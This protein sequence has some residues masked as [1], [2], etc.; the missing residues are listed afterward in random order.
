MYQ[1]VHN[2]VMARPMTFDRAHALDRALKLFWRQGY[3]ATSLAQ[4]L[5]TMD[6]GRSSFYAAFGDKRSLFIEVLELFGD[7][8]RQMLEDVADINE[9]LLSIQRFFEN[10]TFH[11]PN[12]RADAG[13]M[14]VNTILELADV[15]NELCQ[16]ASRKLQQVEDSFAEL[17]RPS[18]AHPEAAAAIVMT[19]NKGI[20]VSS[21]S[22]ASQQELQQVISS[23]LSLLDR[24]A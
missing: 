21:R 2:E 11:V 22:G 10:T 19:L 7:R 5:E 20:R 8:T 12:W 18:Q 24:A 6:I 9:P 14:M 1:L 4:L 15:D 13:C 23:T 16:L 3:T 17:L